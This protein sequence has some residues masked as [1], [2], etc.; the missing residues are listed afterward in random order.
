MKLD[1]TRLVLNGVFIEVKKRVEAS[2]SRQGQG[3][4]L[5]L[6]SD[7]TGVPL[8]SAIDGANVNKFFIFLLAFTAASSPI[9]SLSAEQ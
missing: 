4:M 3:T 7:R 5:E 8:G 9:D 6:A 2:P 1:T